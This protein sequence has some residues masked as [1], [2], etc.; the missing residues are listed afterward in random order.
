MNPSTAIFH[1]HLELH[2]RG[3][4]DGYQ[5]VID[6]DSS[7]QF[8]SNQSIHR[9]LQSYNQPEATQDDI[10]LENLYERFGLLTQR[11]LGGKKSASCVGHNLNKPL[12]NNELFNTFDLVTDHG[13]SEYVF[14][15]EQALESMH[16]LCRP[17]GMIV[18]W[19]SIRGGTGYHN[20][21]PEIYED[22]AATNNY[23][24]LFSAFEVN[25]Q[26]IPT[27][28][29]VDQILNDKSPIGACFAFRKTTDNKFVAPY[30][31]RLTRQELG[32]VSF[33]EIYSTDPLRRSYFPVT[34]EETQN[35][36][37]VQLALK[38][39]FRCLL[40]FFLPFYR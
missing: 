2:A 27:S 10:C 31:Y 22:T 24:I 13:V 35:E 15:S 20:L 34:V 26:F 25:G 11:R 30:Q 21:I 14:S 9:L 6:L 37:P 18:V 16:K 4:Y 28:S 5:S 29:R 3:L 38:V 39:L 40:G 17:G 1:L 19:F 23:E 12:N 33:E 7:A 36:I 8:K 32:I